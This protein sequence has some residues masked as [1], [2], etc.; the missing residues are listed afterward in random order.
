MRPDMHQNWSYPIEGARS[1]LNPVSHHSLPL[2]S[3]IASPVTHALSASAA[4]LL[5]PMGPPQ[6]VCT[7]LSFKNVI[8]LR[9]PELTEVVFFSGSQKQ[10]HI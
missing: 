2:H 8:D 9:Q 1:C 7:I 3:L 5:D 10:A 4:L 6:E